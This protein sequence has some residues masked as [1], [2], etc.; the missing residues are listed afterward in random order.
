MS[1]RIRDFVARACLRVLPTVLRRRLLLRHVK[2]D[3]AKLAG[4]RIVRAIDDDELRGA[5]RLVHDAYVANGIIDPN[6]GG[7]HVTRYSV[8]PSSLI[9]VAK[10]EDGRVVATTMRVR[11]QPGMG[12][13]MDAPHRGELDALRAKGVALGEFSSTA[14]DPAF[15][16]S[17]VIFYLYRAVIE[18]AMRTGLQMLV[19]RAHPRSAI[20][21]ENLLTCERIGRLC[22]DALLNYRP[23]AGFVVT[24]STVVARLRARYG[25]RPDVRNPYTIFFGREL[26]IRLDDTAAREPERLRALAALDEAAWWR[27]RAERQPL[28]A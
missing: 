15:R 23:A 28:A 27:T 16:G 5:A 6:P 21:Y 25:D 1:S 10:T 9:Y 2:I 13:P 11:D 4:L 12:V 7:L 8:S 17:G 22:V 24:L 19:M 26:P 3:R 14:C 20:V 18:V